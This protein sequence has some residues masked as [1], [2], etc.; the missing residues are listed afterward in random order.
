MKRWGG[1]DSTTLQFLLATEAYGWFITFGV[2]GCDSVKTQL[3]V[4]V[5]CLWNKKTF[6]EQQSWVQND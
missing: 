4:W 1:L 5:T 3:F 6:V 2:G